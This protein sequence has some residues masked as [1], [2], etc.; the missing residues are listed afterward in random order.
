MENN[1][2]AQP[3]ADSSSEEDEPENLSYK[4]IIVGNSTVGKT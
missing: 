1:G 3:R 4:I 2:G